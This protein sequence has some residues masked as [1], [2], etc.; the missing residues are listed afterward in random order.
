MMST[1]REA[2]SRSEEYLCSWRNPPASMR[3][4]ARAVARLSRSARSPMTSLKRSRLSIGTMNVPLDS[5]IKPRSAVRR[6]I[7]ARTG[8][9]LVPSAAASLREVS[10]CPGVN[11]PDI[12]ALRSSSYTR[13]CSGANSICATGRPDTMKPQLSRK[14]N[15]KL[16][17]ADDALGTED[18][19]Q[20]QSQRQHDFLG[21]LRNLNTSSAKV[22]AAFQC[23]QQFTH[24]RNRH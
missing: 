21:T 9:S 4:Q 17:V 19:N 18:Q 15:A 23:P 12:R 3:P 2:S 6:E 7:A 22:E 16:V 24:G 8:M 20:K 10:F 5:W 11:L 1:R 14:R 13:S